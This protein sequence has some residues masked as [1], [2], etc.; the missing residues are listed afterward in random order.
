MAD[1]NLGSLLDSAKAASSIFNGTRGAASTPPIAGAPPSTGGSA[2]DQILA[3]LN[4]QP[5]PW[6]HIADAGSVL[7]AFSQGQK[8]DRMA[9]GNLR[10]GFDQM[11]LNR[12]TDQ[13]K[14]GIEAQTGRNQNEAD[15]LRKLQQ[16]SYLAGGGSQYTAPSFMLGGQM[17]TAVDPGFGPQ[18]AS[19]AE[20]QGAQALQEQ[21]LS[22]LQ[23]G[24]SFSPSFTYQPTDVNEYAKPGISEQIG[25]YG[26]LAGG[27]LGA[28]GNIFG[29]SPQNDGAGGGSTGALINA[30]QGI[31]HMLGAGGSAV[32][33]ALSGSM[34]GVGGQ[35]MNLALGGES[36]ATGAAAGAG[37]LMSGVAGKALP[38]LGAVTGTMGLMHNQGLGHNVMN[39]ATAGASIGSMVPG[40]GTAIGGAL[41]A[42][43]GAL[44][45]IG[46][47]SQ[48]ELA[49]RDSVGSVINSITAGATPQQRAEAQHA[50]F[51]HP[52][53]ALALI[54]VRDQLAKQGRDPNQAN[55]LIDQLLHSTKGGTQAVNNAANMIYG[56]FR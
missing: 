27:V 49:G 31:A 40:L 9:E 48:Q 30:G 21:M 29:G 34:L 14:L 20:Q 41:G 47:P 38:V 2:I 42:G 32:N 17:R 51:D 7:G 56:A 37:G 8:A 26:G 4:R 1:F 23:P 6:D 19:V 22:R 16:T 35:G 52:E 46:A 12:E 3:G 33:P 24:G 54:T 10:Q 44:R 15:A 18:G 39:G 45:G 50:G 43:I 25:N 53:Q 13:N 36:A 55:S 11:M 28:L 5:T